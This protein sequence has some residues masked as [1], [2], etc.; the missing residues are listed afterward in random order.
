MCLRL[1]LSSKR[2]VE[3]TVRS[4][5]VFWCLPMLTICALY[6]F[7]FEVRF[8]FNLASTNSLSRHQKNS[9]VVCIPL[10]AYLSIHLTGAEAPK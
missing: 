4:H 2:L 8:S 1:W 10:S 6:M 5:M 7:S 9:R 3:V